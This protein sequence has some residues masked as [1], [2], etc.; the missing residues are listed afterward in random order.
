MGQAEHD[1]L[2]LGAALNTVKAT[3]R[4]RQYTVLYSGS[5]SGNGCA[6]VRVLV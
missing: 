1:L 5:P 2:S 3:I 4:C 6:E